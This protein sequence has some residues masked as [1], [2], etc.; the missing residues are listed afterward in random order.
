[1]KQANG[2]LEHKN[3]KSVR[4]VSRTC[5]SEMT[6]KRQDPSK[7]CSILIAENNESPLLFSYFFDKEDGELLIIIPDVDYLAKIDGNTFGCQFS[8]GTV[9]QTISGS[10]NQAIG[11][12]K[13]GIF[14]GNLE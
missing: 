4:I 1:M 3:V 12:I 8:D 11:N 10:G 7:L 2:F 6:C 5:N 13:G 9:S 14:V